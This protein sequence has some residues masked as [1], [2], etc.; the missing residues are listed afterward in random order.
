MKLWIGVVGCLVGFYCT[1]SFAERTMCLLGNRSDNPRILIDFSHAGEITA[2]IRANDARNLVEAKYF[3][4][5]P[6]QNTVIISGSAKGI[7]Q[8]YAFYEKNDM[9]ELDYGMAVVIFEGGA[10]YST[11]SPCGKESDPID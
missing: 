3:H 5:D 9:G 7:H 10:S 2:E 1:E 11:H 8:F 6:S 4:L